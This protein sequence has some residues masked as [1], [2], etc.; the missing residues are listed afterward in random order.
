[1]GE[2]V[3]KGCVIDYESTDV[4][5]SNYRAILTGNKSG[6]TGGNGRVL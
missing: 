1:M 6:I 4:T 3:Y 2:D 5:V